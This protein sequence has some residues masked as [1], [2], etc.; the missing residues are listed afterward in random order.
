MTTGQK[1]ILQRISEFFTTA[2]TAVSHR[3][4]TVMSRFTPWRTEP[5]ND[6]TR[7]DYDYWRRA[8]RAQVKGLELS[9]LLIKPLVNKTAGWVLGRSPAFSLENETT[10][11]E[12]NNWWADHHSEVLNAYK[13][14]V[15]LGDGFIVVNPDLTLTLIPP[16]HVDPIIDENDYS[17]Q[18]GWRVTQTF[19]H[20]DYTNQKMTVIDEFTAVSRERIVQFNGRETE[21]T[22][23]PNLLGLVPVIHVANNVEPG[24]TFGRPEAEALVNVLQRY[25]V[26]LEAGVEGNE[27][28]GRPTPVLNFETKE[29]LNTFWDLYGETERQTL[30]DGSTESST[31]LSVDLQKL[32][33]VSGAN[34]SYESPGSFIGDAVQLLEIMFYLILEHTELPEFVFGNAISSSKASAESQMPVFVRFIEMKQGEAIGWIKQLLEVV[35]AM[36]SLSRPGV[37]TEIPAIQWDDMTTDDGNLTLETIRW[38]LTEGLIDERTALQLAP[39]DIEDIDAVLAKAKEEREERFP[40]QLAPGNTAVDNNLQDEINR[41]ELDN[42]NG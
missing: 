6:W 8:H 12:L 37:T 28:Q 3:V 33:T 38:A 30:P 25:G 7:P 42:V 34:F 24:E 18:I 23:Y 32:L 35:L 13:E 9:G 15:K 41:L 27:L 36:M 39:V 40:E 17:V 4:R 5:V 21:R 10:A 29:D 2:N 20:P 31:V 26:I 19:I 11:D 16:Q 14:S 22:S 1:S